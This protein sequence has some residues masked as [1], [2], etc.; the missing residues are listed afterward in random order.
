M[1]SSRSKALSDNLLSEQKR[2]LE[3]IA[4]GWQA[5]ADDIPVEN[6]V[7][8]ETTPPSLLMHAGLPIGEDHAHYM[9]IM[10][11]EQDDN[12]QKPHANQ[13]Y[14]L[15]LLEKHQC[16]EEVLSTGTSAGNLILSVG[17]DVDVP[18]QE[19]LLESYRSTCEIRV[20]R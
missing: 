9:D 13:Y 7:E 11:E 19:G 20:D 15:D 18:E 6:A 10:R 14:N 1:S 5:G 16:A 8:D 4:V 2:D 12:F 3:A 17:L